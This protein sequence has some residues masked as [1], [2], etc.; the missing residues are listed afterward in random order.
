MDADLCEAAGFKHGGHNDEITASVDQ[1]A[2]RLIVGKAKSRVLTPHLVV[3][4]VE[5][6]LHA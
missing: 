1:V 2:Q 4:G 5:L 3:Q 6:C